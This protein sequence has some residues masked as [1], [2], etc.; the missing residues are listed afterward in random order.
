[1]AFPSQRVAGNYY[2]VTQ[3]NCTCED[4]TRHPNQVCKHRLAV[5]IHCARVIGKPMPAS[6]TVDWL[7]QMA[8][9]K[10]KVLE[11]VR[12]PEGDITWRPLSDKYDAIFKR[13]DDD[14]LR[15]VCKES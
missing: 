10:G 12:E 6:D 2:L 13:F 15:S 9:D 3:T 11:M 14:G 5:Q 4:A 7:A 8:A 1:M